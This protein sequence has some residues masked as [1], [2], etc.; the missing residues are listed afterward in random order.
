MGTGPRSLC[1]GDEVWV[2]YCGGLPY[3]LQPL[4]DGCC[5][6]VGE[7]FVYGV[8]HGEALKMDVAREDVVLE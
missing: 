6:L 7:S 8:M 1:V 5:R 4:L 2:L 3:V